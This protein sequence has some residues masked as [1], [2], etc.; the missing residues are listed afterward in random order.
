MIRWLY[1]TNAKDIGTLYL[2]F[3][4]FAGMIGTAFSV[5][6]RMEL[7]SPGVQYLNGDHQ[8]YNVIITAHAL[9]MI[10]FMVITFSFTNPIVSTNYRNIN[11]NINTNNN[12]NNNNNNI[13]KYTTHV[14]ENPYH[15][16]KRIHIIANKIQGVYIFQ[17][18]DGSTYVGSSVSLYS[19]V[20]SYFIPSIL[21][22]A[23]RRVLH[24][25]RING[26]DNVTLILHILKPDSTI[27]SL[28][29]EQYFIDTLKPNLNVDLLANSTGF[30]EP[31]SEYWR[32][33]LRKLRGTGIYIYDVTTGKLVFTSDS[34]QYIL[35]YIGIDRATVLRYTSDTKLFLGR[36]RFIRDILPELDNTE[37]IN[38]EEFKILLKNSREEFD[39]SKVQPKSKQ[40][41]A[42]NFNNPSLTKV[43][44]SINSFAKAVKGDRGTIRQYIN[45]KDKLYRKQWQLTT[46]SK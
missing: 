19:R 15:S 27:S 9:I 26:F 40:I 12:I 21:R 6:I 32:N 1:S 16:R 7:A 2:V 20:T 34:I 11:T 3:G 39:N 5:L 28:E 45:N 41:L 44:S 46:I 43:Y 24:Y 30:H 25:F 23:N 18:K 10:F 29:L 36:F 38:L 22:S 13:N 31:M 8:L 37:S 4:L 35:D 42:E 17:C 33:Y 14:I